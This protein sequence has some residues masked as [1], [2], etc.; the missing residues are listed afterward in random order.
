[1]VD[2]WP[3]ERLPGFGEGFDLDWNHLCCARSGCWYH[4]NL[5]NVFMM[6][7][8]EKFKNNTTLFLL[9]L[10]TPAPSKGKRI[11]PRTLR[12]V[13][14][15]DKDMVF[16]PLNIN[17]NHWVRL[18]IDRSRTTIYCFESFNKRPNQNLLA[19]PIQKD[20]DNCGLFIILHFWRRFVKEMR[21]D[22]TTVGLLRRQWDVLRTVVDFSDASKGEQD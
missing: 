8:V 5:I 16:M 4:D 10:H 6:T 2:T 19:A 9:S 20:S 13:A 18:V 21:S 22:Y 14:A 11:P 7:L 15:A 1:M 17:G 3:F 12:L